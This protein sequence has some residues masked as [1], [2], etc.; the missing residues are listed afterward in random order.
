[1]PLTRL[2]G[3][4]ISLLLLCTAADARTCKMD[5][6]AALHVQDGLSEWTVHATCTA[7][8]LGER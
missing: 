2:L 6:G 5:D 7:L 1:M 8:D 4:A 3:H